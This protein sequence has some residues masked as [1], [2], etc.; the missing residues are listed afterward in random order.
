MLLSYDLYSWFLAAQRKR[1]EMWAKVVFGVRISVFGFGFGIWDSVY[2]LMVS[3]AF[4]V[5]V[6]AQ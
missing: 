5:L 1:K 2:W 3:C 6:I 4:F